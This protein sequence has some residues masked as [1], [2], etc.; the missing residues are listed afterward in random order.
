MIR[1]SPFVPHRCAC[2]NSAARHSG[3]SGFLLAYMGRGSMSAGRGLIIHLSIHSSRP[4]PGAGKP[5]FALGDARRAVGPQTDAV[6][7]TG[8]RCDARDGRHGRFDRNTTCTGT[9]RRA[10]R[11]RGEF[12]TLVSRT[13]ATEISSPQN[14]D[15]P[16]PATSA[17]SVRRPMLHSSSR[18]LN[19]F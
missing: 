19:F 14:P 10:R 9:E 15:H 7:G 11:C 4:A 5:G 6:W 13:I 1:T 18:V 17:S 8:V 12:E 2:T 3:T 16:S